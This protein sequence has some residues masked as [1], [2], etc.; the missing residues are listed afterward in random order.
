MSELL[1]VYLELAA[2]KSRQLA[3]DSKRGRT[4]PGDVQRGIAEIREMLD[5][6]SSEARRHDP[7]DR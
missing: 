6:A 4:W 5:K 3:E 1:A 2:A 7:S